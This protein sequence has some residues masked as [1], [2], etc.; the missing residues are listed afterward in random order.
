MDNEKT[1][2]LLERIKNYKKIF[3]KYNDIKKNKL[4]ESISSPELLNLLEFIPFLFTVNLSEFPGFV[5]GENIPGGIYNY[6]PSQK[7]VSYLRTNHPSFVFT[8]VRAAEQFIQMFALIGS[9]GTIAFTAESDF[10]FWIC[11]DVSTITPEGLNAFR[12]KCRLIEDWIKE[13]Y[14]REVHFFIND[15]NQIRNNIFD[16][17]DEYGLTGTS[18]GQLLKEEFFRSSIILSGKLP[19]WWVV[20]ADCGDAEY[21][22]WF[23][24]I[25]GTGYEYDFVELGNLSKIVKE[26]F[27]IAAL[28]QIMKSL[29][30][31]F[32][33][34]MKLGLLERYIH[35]K[36]ENPFISN[37]IKKNIQEGKTDLESIDAYLIMFNQVYE[38]Y[39]QSNDDPTALNIIKTCFYLKVDPRLSQPADK[40]LNPDKS[41]KML[42]YT[43]KWRWDA[44]TVKHVDNF[45]KWEIKSVNQLLN[46]A[47]KNILKGYK[48][49][50]NMID[51][52]GRVNSINHESLLHINRKIY[53]HFQPED[54]KIDNTLSFKTYPPEKLLLLAFIRDKFNNE[55]WI[56]S[57]RLIVNEK[58]EQ[59]MIKKHK[60]L[61]VL[62]T[63]ISL[64][65][66]YQKNYTRLD[67]EQGFYQ[68]DTNFIRDLILELSSHFTIKKLDIHN[69]YF[70]RDVFPIVSYIIINPF[71]K[72]SSKIDEIFF[73]YHNSWGETKFEIFHKESDIS[74][75]LQ[76][77]I[78]GALISGK[79]SESSLY[80]TS[81]DPFRSTKDFTRIKN[82]I[83][84][85]FSFFTGNEKK[86]KLRYITMLGNAYVIF[87]NIMKRGTESSVSFTVCDTEIKMLYSIAYNK[88]LKNLIA[89]DT[90]IQE[91]TYVREML[92]RNS[93]NSV[94]IFFQTGNKYCY[95]FVLNERGSLM[96]FRK[97][98][99]MHSQ[100]LG[101]LISFAKSSINQVLDHNKNSVFLEEEN[102]IKVYRF[103][104]DASHNCTVTEIRHESDQGIITGLKKIIPLTLS[105][106]LLETG[107]IG[108]RFTLPDGGFSEIFSRQDVE[109]IS[110]EISVLMESV[111]GYSYF[112][113]DVNLD[114]IEI[115]MYMN[116][117]SFAFSE[118]NRFEVL[119]EKNIKTV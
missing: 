58:A 87:S 57:K 9:T 8:K 53:S 110:S 6:T 60:N 17:D 101:S 73:L 80:I 35:D 91:L 111:K 76:R 22:E 114:N 67:I 95:Y 92:K 98:T 71:S 34:I 15:I 84:S 23:S 13:N 21:A 65:G 90:H 74:G 77:I 78:N 113:T 116:Y 47:K 94:Q 16:E 100:Y 61:F 118:K 93:Y 63:W 56:L 36:T 25:K 109:Q 104:R 10:D 99:E 7:A 96:F 41:A 42:E 32:K 106:H 105:L 40:Q 89:A 49:I 37:F 3:I 54:N 51:A 102:R 75:I 28:F 20:P 18:L 69:S 81:S 19:F 14:N 117:T 5:E 11:G 108:Y 1:T 2:D 39:S 68:M 85:L 119:I 83:N 88:G 29:G 4:Y 62:I 107:D 30:N 50:L 64:N 45:D 115:K 46:N 24:V 55:S 86:Q 33:S 66:L 12:T 72:Y 112:A 44:D 27:L 48:N 97:K 103:E 31:P 38:Y 79:D 82:S 43:N 52:G 70:I 59:I 26:D